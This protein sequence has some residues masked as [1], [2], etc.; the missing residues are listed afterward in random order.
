MKKILL[1]VLVLSAA[2]AYSQEIRMPDEKRKEY[3]KEERQATNS[4]SKKQS[5]ATNQVTEEERRR[6]AL[7]ARKRAAQASKNESGVG[8]MVYCII[9]EQQSVNGKKTIVSVQA[10]PTMEKHMSK[11]D[12]QA[13]KALSLVLKKSDYKNGL[14]ALNSF[15]LNGWELVN[16][17]SYMNP[18]TEMI[19]HN[20]LM[21]YRIR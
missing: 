6:E 8:T 1:S 20:Y 9:E 4:A 2:G 16:S 17:S 15:S 19:V 5:K 18:E 3:I 21:R 7:E 14:H 13:Y 11:S 12:K 10:D